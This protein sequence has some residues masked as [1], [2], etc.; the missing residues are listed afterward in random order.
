MSAP[1]AKP[2]PVLSNLE[3]IFKNSGHE[4]VVHSWM[5]HDGFENLISEMDLGLQLSYSES[6]NIVTADFI[7]MGISIIVSPA[8]SWMPKMYMSSTTNYDKVVR[9]IILFYKLRNSKLLRMPARRALRKYNRN[10]KHH[11]KHFMKYLEQ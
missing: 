2:N 3:Q 4:L 10:S 6:F 7:N 5:P 8:I 1:D 11:W 9:D